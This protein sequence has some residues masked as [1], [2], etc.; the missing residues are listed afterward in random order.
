[1][2]EILLKLS[3]SIDKDVSKGI[4]EAYELSK[5]L[6]IGCSLNCFN[7]Y[8]FTIKPDMTQEDIDKLKNINIVR[9]L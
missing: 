3:L 1:M 2:K 8:L 5:R 6:N 9:A 7:Q 4:D